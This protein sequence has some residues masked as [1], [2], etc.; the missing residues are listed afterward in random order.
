MLLVQQGGHSVHVS[1]AVTVVVDLSP[2]RR[3]DVKCP[4]LGVQWCFE[5][6]RMAAPRESS[7]RQSPW[8]VGLLPRKFASGTCPCNCS[9]SLKCVVIHSSW[10]AFTKARVN[11]K[12]ILFE[13]P[14]V[15]YTC[16]QCLGVQLSCFT[17][18]SPRDIHLRNRLDSFYFWMPIKSVG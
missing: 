7:L 2:Q 15:F 9:Y 18:F 16:R 8:C 11:L 1:S 4:S 12:N 3:C 14:H 13:N 5:S 17:L 10:E 6:P